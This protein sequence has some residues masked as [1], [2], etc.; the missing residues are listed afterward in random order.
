MATKS[1]LNVSVGDTE[2]ELIESTATDTQEDRTFSIGNG[3]KEISATA[4]GSNSGTSWEEIESKTIDPSG[5]ETII[6]GSNHY[7]Y[8]KL[9]GKT[10]TSGDTSIVDAFLTYTPPE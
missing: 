5:Y 10:T 2:T 3:D 6:L 8:V 7:L 4:W 9:T 1:N